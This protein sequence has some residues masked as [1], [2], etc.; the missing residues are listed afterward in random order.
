[1]NSFL[2]LEHRGLS[3]DTCWLMNSEIFALVSLALL[4]EKFM[5]NLSPDLGK[6][7]VAW[8]NKLKFK[9]YLDRLVTLRHCKD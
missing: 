2:L 9:F 8:G 5:I 3:S 1:M 4:K 7:E 6:Y